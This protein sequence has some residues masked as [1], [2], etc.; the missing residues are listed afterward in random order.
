M[1]ELAESG[2]RNREEDTEV[3]EPPRG[4]FER[5][6]G[7]VSDQQQE[8]S[9]LRAENR[10]LT[11]LTERDAQAMLDLRDLIEEQRAVIARLRQAVVYTEVPPDSLGILE[12]GDLV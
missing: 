5:L 4:A 12:P 3:G 11:R 6:C 7:I 2:Y 10:R 1:W 8:L 9:T